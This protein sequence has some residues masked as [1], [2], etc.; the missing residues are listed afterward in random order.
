MCRF[1]AWSLLWLSAA[2]APAAAAEYPRFDN[3]ALQRG[4][5][6]WLGT[7][8]GCHGIGVAGAPV[9]GDREAWA[10]RIARGREVLYEHALEGFFGP[11]GT[12]MPARGGN[13]TLSTEEVR[14]AVDYMVRLASEH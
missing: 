8:E 7:C 3:A 11:G 5:E 13:D 2:L 10:E 4:R 6:I 14:L 9:A 12:M 1:R